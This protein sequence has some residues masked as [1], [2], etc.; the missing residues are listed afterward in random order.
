MSK[1]SLHVITFLGASLLAG[2]THAA[3]PRTPLVPLP[4]V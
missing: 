4:S 1:K 3:E 2:A